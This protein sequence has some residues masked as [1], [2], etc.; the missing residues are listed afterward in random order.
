MSRRCKGIEDD[1]L[2]RFRGDYPRLIN[3]T[4]EANIVI[5]ETSAQ[6]EEFGNFKRKSRLISYF[7]CCVSLFVSFHFNTPEKNQNF[8]R[9]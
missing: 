4:E 2:D 6:A 8:G 5:Q 7:K 9:K 1:I 3:T